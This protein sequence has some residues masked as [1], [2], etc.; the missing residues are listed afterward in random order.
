MAITLISAA[1]SGV[2]LIIGEALISKRHLFQCGYPK[3]QCLLEGDAYL[4]P[5]VCKRKYGIYI[6]IIY[7]VY[8]CKVFF[9]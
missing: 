5:E 1:F 7:K 9:P 3:A 2:M 6:Y 8:I 4:R